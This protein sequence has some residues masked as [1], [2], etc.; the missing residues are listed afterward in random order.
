MAP[1]ITHIS[2]VTALLSDILRP[3]FMLVSVISKSSK[4]HIISDVK[5]LVIAQGYVVYRSFHQL[6]LWPR[7]LSPLRHVPTATGA[8]FI[9]GH[10]RLI[11]DN[12]VCTRLCEWAKKYGPV[13]RFFGPVGL[14]CL[15]FLEPEPLHQ[16]LS[17]GWL[18]YPRV[19]IIHLLR[20][21]ILNT[22][23]SRRS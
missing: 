14:E 19:R 8:E 7:Y 22:L 5:L 23:Q 18:D 2:Q 13:V 9:L 17:K 11:F 4:N 12:E 6:V 20:K 15:F 16:I 3:S 21:Y 10:S 1:A